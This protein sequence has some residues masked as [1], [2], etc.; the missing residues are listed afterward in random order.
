MPVDGV[1]ALSV[2]LDPDPFQGFGA[3]FEAPADTAAVR[4]VRVEAERLLTAVA[5]A[6]ARPVLAGGAGS[7]GERLAKQCP[8]SAPVSGVVEALGGVAKRSPLP[9]GSERSGAGTESR[10]AIGVQKRQ[11]VGKAFLSNPLAAHLLDHPFWLLG[12]LPPRREV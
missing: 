4:V 7:R 5:V 10:A 9:G 2:Y 6:G 8:C 3:V 1:A 11:Q 12:Y